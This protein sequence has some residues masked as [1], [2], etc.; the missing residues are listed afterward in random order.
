M[1]HLQELKKNILVV[2]DEESLR[3]A[4]ALILRTNGYHVFEA[5]SGQEALSA[6][7]G[8]PIDLILSDVRMPN[9]DGIE[10]LQNVRN[11]HH[12]KPV[13]FLVTGFTDLKIED[14]YD[15]G[16]DAVFPKP[17]DRKVLLQAIKNKL[18]PQQ[19]QWQQ[20]IP[21][22]PQAPLNMQIKVNSLE[23]I[24]NGE[25][26]KMGRGGF[27]VA[28]DENIPPEGSCVQFSISSPEA[29][30]EGFGIVRWTRRDQ[31]ESRRTGCG[32]EFYQIQ[33]SCRPQMLRLIHS[34]PTKSLIPKG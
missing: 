22:Q 10:L 7:K 1:E 4:M 31:Q 27:F 26:L 17:F 15:M 30:L 5:A 21:T 14:V 6:L 18:Q 34:Q 25:T 9:G 11:L 24:L 16:A 23:G 33:D 2:E 20:V 19:V 13:L 28:I 29:S 12:E 3:M 32:V 8:Q